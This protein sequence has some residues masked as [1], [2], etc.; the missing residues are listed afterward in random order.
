MKTS[1]SSSASSFKPINRFLE[2][3]GK[4]VFWLP[5]HNFFRFFNAQTAAGER[6]RWQVN[7]FFFRLRPGQ[8]F[9]PVKDFD[10]RCFFARGNIQT[11][12]KFIF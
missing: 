12:D 1:S 2:A 6:V 3:L 7:V 8:L 9:N 5:T 10:D 4:I 11:A